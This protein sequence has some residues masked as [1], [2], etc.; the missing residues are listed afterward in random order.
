MTTPIKM[1]FHIDET[2]KKECEAILKDLGL[3][4]AI[5]MNMFAKAVIRYKGL[6]FDIRQDEIYPNSLDTLFE[7]YVGEYKCSEFDFGEE[8]GAE[9]V[10]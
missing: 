4:M 2:T 9:K 10:W 6:P 1:T 7:N 5:G 8:V 3:S